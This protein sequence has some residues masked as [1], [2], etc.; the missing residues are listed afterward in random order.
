MKEVS[1]TYGSNAVIASQDP[2]LS[3]TEE[4]ANSIIKRCEPEKLPAVLNV[5]KSVFI[6]YLEDND[7]N[8]RKELELINIVLEEIKKV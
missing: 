7:R 2:I 4:F 3:E 5:V 6:F 8:H 1:Y